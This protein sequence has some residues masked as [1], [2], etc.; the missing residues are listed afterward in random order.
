ME[1][2]VLF[3]SMF[4]LMFLSVPIGIV[5]GASVI[6]TLLYTGTIPLLM[7]AQN[8]FAAL[9]SFPLLAIPFF[10]L[11]GSLMGYGG[12][13]RRLVML[14]EALIGAITGGL[15]MVTITACMFFAAISGSAPATVSAI[16]SFMIPAMK[17]K[18]YDEDFAAALTAIA[19]SIG[20]IIP[21]SIPF[22]LYGVISGASIGE[23]F[24]SGIV[25]G[26]LVGIAL[27]IVSYFIAKKRNWMVSTERIPLLQA[28]RESIWALFVPII[29]LGGIYGGIFT[30]TEAAVVA[31][32]YALVIGKFVYKELDFKVMYEAFKEASLVNG[33]TSFMIGFSMS[34]A[35]FITMEQIPVKITEMMLSISSST[36]VILLLINILLLIVGCFVD[37]ISATIVLTPIL[38][39]IVTKLGM[40][41]VHFGLQMVIAFCIGYVTPPYGCNLFVASAISNVSV[42]RISKA[43][44]PMVAIMTLLLFLFT[45]VPAIGMSLVWLLR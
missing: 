33:A 16:G 32:V 30:P 38:L 17:E 27:M 40:D 39:P 7:V 18:R 4:V 11:A 14:A 8:A 37:T 12:I 23:L 10:I 21:P 15:A 25:P 31:S 26:I 1:I 20:A 45:Y 22:V 24:I 35:A 19:G 41:P 28:L 2:A 43:V 9:D 3:G 29:I 13:S 6:I 34:F 5:L 36:I 42:I 44:L